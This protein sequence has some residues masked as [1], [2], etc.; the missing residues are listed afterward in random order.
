[1]RGGGGQS[2]KPVHDEALNEGEDE[3]VGDLNDISTE[4][5]AEGVVQFGAF[6]FQENTSF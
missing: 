5:V 1:L 2:N 6:L 3:G 4:E